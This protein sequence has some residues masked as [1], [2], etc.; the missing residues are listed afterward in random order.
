[1]FWPE[2]VMPEDGPDATG[3]VESGIGSTGDELTGANRGRQPAGGSLEPA[4]QVG[5]VSHG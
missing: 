1:M 5:R 3:Q 2:G 4:G